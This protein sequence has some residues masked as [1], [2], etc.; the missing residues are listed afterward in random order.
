MIFSQL[1]IMKGNRRNCMKETKQLQVHVQFSHGH[2]IGCKT[3]HSA[4]AGRKEL[5]RKHCLPSNIIYNDPTLEVVGRCPQY[6][7]IRISFDDERT[8]K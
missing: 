6:D 5:S 1:K 3:R 4:M 2:Y 8:C 7:Q